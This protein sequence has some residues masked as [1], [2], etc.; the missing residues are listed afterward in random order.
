M[1]PNFVQQIVSIEKDLLTSS[2]NT[3]NFW[4]DEKCEQFDN[5]YM[6]EYEKKLEL[7]IHGGSE[8]YGMGLDELL[9]FLDQKESEM[10]M[11][12]RL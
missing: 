1:I 3:A 5:L 2:A 11:L 4:Q 10:E 9:V 8:N 12:G 6:N 7:L